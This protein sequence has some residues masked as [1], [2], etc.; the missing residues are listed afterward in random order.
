MT[1]SGRLSSKRPVLIIVKM[2]RKDKKER[3]DYEQGREGRK[4]WKKERELRFQCNNY[5]GKETW[6]NSR[7]TRIYFI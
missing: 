4:R 5:K 7:P 3:R 6:H 1:I 2:A